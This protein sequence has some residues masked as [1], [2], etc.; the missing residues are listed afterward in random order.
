MVS[1]ITPRRRNM[2]KLIIFVSLLILFAGCES[3][4]DKSS[5]E[6]EEVQEN[7]L[8]K[9][10]NDSYTFD[11]SIG[12]SEVYLDHTHE[13][14]KTKHLVKKTELGAEYS[15]SITFNDFNL[16]K[17]HI[18]TAYIHDSWGDDFFVK[19]II[20]GDQTIVVH[21]DGFWVDVSGANGK[22]G[23]NTDFL[24]GNWKYE[25][26]ISYV[27]APSV[28]EENKIRIYTFADNT[29][30]FYMKRMDL[31]KPKGESF[32]ETS[33]EGTYKLLYDYKEQKFWLSFD[34]VYSVRK[35]FEYDKENKTFTI[36]DEDGIGRTYKW[37]PN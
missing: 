32:I 12:F 3:F 17:N 16:K 24:I 14:Y 30:K 7:I 31:T 34:S 5:E 15:N 1:L 18:Y 35:T 23:E 2:K 20:P 11:I 4:L 29:Y 8:V 28:L 19:N 37:I 26:G 13:P 21:Y 9:V 27:S 25:G 6:R 10:Y 36:T 22:E 33:E